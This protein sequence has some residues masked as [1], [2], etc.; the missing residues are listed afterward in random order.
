MSMSSRDKDNLISA[1]K[2]TKEMGD[3]SE[4]KKLV[5][6]IKAQY[7]AKYGADDDALSDLRYYINEYTRYS[8][9]VTIQSA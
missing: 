7:I 5:S 9:D 8:Y 3:T 6:Q 2:A 4:A 1:L